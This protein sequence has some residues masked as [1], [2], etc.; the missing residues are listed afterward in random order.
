MIC[1]CD[2]TKIVN[3]LGQFPLPVEIVP[4]AWKQTER[5]VE[6]VLAEQGLHHVPIIRRMGAGTR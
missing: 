5:R 2:E 3:C 4:F 6:R 1:I